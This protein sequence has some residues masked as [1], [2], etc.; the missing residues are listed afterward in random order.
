MLLHKLPWYVLDTETSAQKGVP[1]WHPQN[2]LLQ[3][4]CYRAKDGAWFTRY[5]NHGKDFYLHPGNVELHKIGVEQL[6]R[7]GQ[8]GAVVMRDLLDFLFVEEE[9]VIVAHNASFDLDVIMNALEVELGRDFVLERQ[10]KWHWFDT[11]TYFKLVHPDLGII[12]EPSLRPYSLEKL[13]KRFLSK[14]SAHMHNAETDVSMLL[15]LFKDVVLPNLHAADWGKYLVTGPQNWR[16][17][18]IRD[19]QGFGPVRTQRICEIVNAVFLQEKDEAVSAGVTDQ[20]LRVSDLIFYA[21]IR[22]RDGPKGMDWTE[23]CRH[24]EILLREKPIEISCDTTIARLL[25]RV[26]GLYMHDFLFH[27]MREDGNKQFF[28]VLRGTARAFLPFRITNADARLLLEDRGWG[29]INEAVAEML[30]SPMTF[31]ELENEFR[32]RVSSN[33][34]TDEQFAHFEEIIRNAMT[35]WG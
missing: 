31:L 30:T 5:I 24:I 2:R 22:M 8:S 32:K 20:L 35:Y 14:V 16:G 29:T 15:T 34:S 3:V 11:L 18:L 23:V 13:C 28:P 9:I 19:I 4:C 21:F 10:L 12:V 27:T 6:Q 25:S 7:E 17:T 33:A 26:C 1:I